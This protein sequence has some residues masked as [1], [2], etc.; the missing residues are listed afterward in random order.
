[1]DWL[2]VVTA[3]LG[4][5]EFLSS[6]EDIFTCLLLWR[7]HLASGEMLNL[8]RYGEVLRTRSRQQWKHGEGADGKESNYCRH[9]K[10]RPNRLRQGPLFSAVVLD[11]SLCVCEMFIHEFK[12]CY[13]GFQ[14]LLGLALRPVLP[15]HQGISAV[16]LRAQFPSLNRIG[17]AF[18]YQSAEEKHDYFPSSVC[19]AGWSELHR[20]LK[21][22]FCSVRVWWTQR[23]RIRHVI[24]LH[25]GFY[26]ILYYY[27][28]HSILLLSF[29]LSFMSRSRFILKYSEVRVSFIWSQAACVPTGLWCRCQTVTLQLC[30]RL[31]LCISP[32]NWMEVKLCW[33]ESVKDR[34]RQKRNVFFFVFFKLHLKKVFLWNQPNEQNFLSMIVF[35]RGP[36]EVN[37]GTF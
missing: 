3:A 2:K 4:E 22:F 23:K 35:L 34:W 28:H 5:E 32:G 25:M 21:G 20:A 19:H 14:Q 27:T 31:F 6:Y 9:T 16:F 33:E 11:L 1:M 7:A 18:F 15:G 30:Q 10:Y 29:F 13:G 26:I 37:Q 12:F 17:A 24:G 8:G 36:S